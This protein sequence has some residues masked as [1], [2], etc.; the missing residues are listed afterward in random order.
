[1]KFRNKFSKNTQM[2]NISKIRP[3]GAGLFHT[4]GR[5]DRH[6]EANSHLSQ[7]W[8]RAEKRDT[9]N[10]R[11][12]GTTSKLLTKYLSNISGKDDVKEL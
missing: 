6:D 3:V 5:T 12:T 2:S 10:K 7:F 4:D 8:E 11:E 9:G 1:L